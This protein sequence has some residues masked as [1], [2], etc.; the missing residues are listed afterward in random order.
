MR[1]DRYLKESNTVSMDV[2][3]KHT[4]AYIKKVK[5][6]MR[7]K[8]Y[9]FKDGNDMIFTKGDDIFEISIRNNMVNTIH[10][11]NR[12]RFDIGFMQNTA[13]MRENILRE[14]MEKHKKLLQDSYKYL[15]KN[16]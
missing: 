13:H 10:H 14:Y 12:L 11:N 8:D 3:K 2:V 7:Q 9:K 1:Y 16:T 15:M 6:M 5:N 4:R